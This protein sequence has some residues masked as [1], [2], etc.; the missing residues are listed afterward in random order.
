MST[1]FAY[2]IQFFTMVVGTGGATY[3]SSEENI[4]AGVVAALGAA[5]AMAQKA[6]NDPRRTTS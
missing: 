3:M 6:L 4:L 2:W 5:G 1:V